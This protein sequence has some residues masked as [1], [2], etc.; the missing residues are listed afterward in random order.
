VRAIAHG[1][2]LAGARFAA[3]AAGLV[4]ALVSIGRGVGR[5]ATT[6]GRGVASAGGVLE[7]RARDAAASTATLWR[8]AR[9]R[10]GAW[11]RHQVAIVLPQAR[12]LSP[13]AVLAVLGLVMFTLVMALWPMSYEPPTMERPPPS[14]TPLALERPSGPDRRPAARAAARGETRPRATAQT[15]G[16]AAREPVTFTTARPP[17]DR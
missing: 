16:P 14:D 17:S 5:G 13:G 7:G 11:A 4:T 1:A 10:T 3:W 8:A 9:R 2:A 15:P 12:A 6:G